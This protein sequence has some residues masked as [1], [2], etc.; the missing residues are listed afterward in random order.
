MQPTEQN[1]PQA[2]SITY[3]TRPA[4]AY[5]RG[6]MTLAAL[7]TLTGVELWARAA[8]GSSPVTAILGLAKAGIILQYFVHLS[9]LW[10]AETHQER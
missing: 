10:S 3:D 9:S 1:K 4:A 2:V 6:V 7:A 8:L 5:R